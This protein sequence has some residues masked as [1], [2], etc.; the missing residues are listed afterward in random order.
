MFINFD[1]FFS[2][3]NFISMQNSIKTVNILFNW[4]YTAFCG[5]NDKKLFMKNEAQREKKHSPSEPSEKL[6][7][8]LFYQNFTG[9]YF[10]QSISMNLRRINELKLFYQHQK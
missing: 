4:L 9:I 5:A 1:W 6:F 8:L 10:Y 7:P 3:Y 2:Q